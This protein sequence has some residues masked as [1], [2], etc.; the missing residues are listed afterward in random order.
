M[1]FKYF[2][3]AFLAAAQLIACNDDS[4]QNPDPMDKEP[5][6]V[7][8]NQPS[9]STESKLVLASDCDQV[10]EHIA[11]VF[12]EEFL[13]RVYPPPEENVSNTNGNNAVF[14]PPS[15]V[16]GTNTQVEGVDEI[17]TVKTDGEHIYALFGQGY[18]QDVVIVKSWPPEEIAEVARLE[19]N[20]RGLL[21]HEDK[22]VVLGDY[23]EERIDPSTGRPHVL[24][25]FYGTQVTIVDVADPANPVIEQ[26]KIIE[27]YLVDGRMIDGEVYLVTSGQLKRPGRLNHVAIATDLDFPQFAPNERPQDWDT[28][29]QLK[30]DIRAPMRV[31][32]VNRLNQ[33][34]LTDLFPVMRDVQSG[35][36]ETLLDC[37]EY[38][39]PPR[40]TEVGFLNVTNFNLGGDTVLE[41]TS[42]ASSGQ[43][44][45][46]SKN[47]L[48]VTT[49]ST[50]WWWGW[51]D[52][53]PKSLVHKFV[54]TPDSRP[55]Y[56]ASGSFTG[57][58]LN[59]FS[60]SEHDGH[61]RVATTETRWRGD[62]EGG[63]HLIVLKE[64]DGELIETGSVRGLAPGE[65]I[66]AIRFLGD[67]AYMVT[68]EAIDPLFTF[69]LSDPANPQLKGELKINGFSSYLHPLGDDHLLAVGQDGTDQGSLNGAHVQIFDVSDLSNPVRTHQHIIGGWAETAWDHKAYTYDAQKKLLAIPAAPIAY[70]GLLVLTVDPQTGFEEVGHIEHNDL[71]QRYWCELRDHRECDDPDRVWQTEMVRSRFIDDY[72][73]SFSS[74]GLRVNDLAALEIERAALVL[75]LPIE[76]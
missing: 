13:S 17:D 21:L 35:S 38:Y 2:T 11:D 41:T 10:R 5:N 61:L 50:R 52:T 26:Q 68:F 25:P 29:N 31:E 67:E 15:D 40:L 56:R 64:E 27:S 33:Q 37:N 73:Y 75:N 6:T 23:E 32:I 74:V 71:A 3:I 48:Y 8:N 4:A 28:I 7:N 14:G 58:V 53:E 42:L 12:T 18:G 43:T 16:S 44:I 66:Y 24:G 57:W 69:D 1:R 45:Y 49:A 72:V 30:A 60:M 51:G 34:P 65:E 9:V 39:L 36:V 46:A 70:N 55:A 47:S 76:E 63:N 62:T 54:L 20:A 19:L 59:Q 22:L